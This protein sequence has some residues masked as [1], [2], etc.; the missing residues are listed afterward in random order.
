MANGVRNV[1]EKIE[2]LQK[3]PFFQ[4]VRFHRD[5]KA[6]SFFSEGRDQAAE[7]QKVLKTAQVLFEFLQ[8][9]SD[10]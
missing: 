10:F 1:L 3:L 2:L 8:D 5:R 7:L 6:E 9:F 4:R